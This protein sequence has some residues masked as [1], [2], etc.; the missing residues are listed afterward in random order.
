MVYV[1]IGYTFGDGMFESDK[2]RGGS[3]Y[4]TPRTLHGFDGQKICYPIFSHLQTKLKKCPHFVDL[5]FTILIE[6]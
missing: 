5:M 4:G 6:F 1:P 2:I 3:P